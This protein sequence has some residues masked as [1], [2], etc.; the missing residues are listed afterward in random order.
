[1]D[2]LDGVGVHGAVPEVQEFVH[3]NENSFQRNYLVNLRRS[4]KR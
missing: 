2:Q 1:L 4:K 3:L